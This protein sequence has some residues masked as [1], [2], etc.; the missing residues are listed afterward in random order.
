MS[1]TRK[2]KKKKLNKNKKK[3]FVILTCYIVTFVITSLFT[4]ST[5]AWFNGSTWQ[6]E[7]VYMG[8]PVY[9]YFSDS[10]GVN[11]TSGEGQ[12]VTHLPANWSK[13]YP[14]MNIHFESRVVLQGHTFTNEDAVG[15][16]FQQNTST[17]VLR[18]RMM[19]TVT[20]RN[21]NTD[22]EVATQLYNWIWPQ[23]KTN[24]I[25]DSGNSGIW[26]FDKLEEN[27]V[28]EDNYFYY[29]AKD[30]TQTN[31]GKY[32]LEEVGGQEVNVS[33]GFLTDT[34]IQIP[35]VIVTNEHADCSLTFTIVFE[36]LQAYFPYEAEDVGV[37]I[38]QGDSSGRFVQEF[39]VGLE[40]PL[41][42]ENS[43]EL[44]EEAG[45][46]PENGYTEEQN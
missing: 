25:I 23:L 19:L 5:L 3:F 6:D 31:T 24:A 46:T 30:Q 41:T 13:L 15:E 39:D 22:S 4:A 12:L 2:K 9:I 43:R 18:A 16:E 29:I 10:T 45:W 32:L 8:G 37:E 44:F 40:K 20:D 35:P 42:I 17:A 28:E 33:V 7:V 1:K 14:G 36:A 21:G 27:T 38:Y 26:V 34:I 11:K